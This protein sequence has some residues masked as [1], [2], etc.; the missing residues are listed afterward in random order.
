MG[1]ALDARA[2]LAPHSGQR[3]PGRQ[4][5]HQGLRRPR[6]ACHALPDFGRLRELAAPAT[7]PALE[8]EPWLR[9]ARLG[10]AA[11]RLARRGP[12]APAVHFRLWRD[13]DRLQPQADHARRGGVLRRLVTCDS[14]QTAAAALA[15][16][17]HE[18][19]IRRTRPRRTPWLRASA[20]PGPALSA[21][22][23]TTPRR[24]AR[25]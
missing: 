12:V 25:P 22:C 16:M 4:P 20:R 8:P 9:A 13:P 21:S 6:R 11:P 18:K 1:P 17:A 3:R 5:G 10:D 2:R 19:S 24:R 7:H 23:R 15:T 14:V